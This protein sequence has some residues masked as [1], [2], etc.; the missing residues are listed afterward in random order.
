LIVKVKLEHLEHLVPLFEAYRSVFGVTDNRQR[1]LDYLTAQIKLG[2]VFYLRFEK[3]KAI[4]FCAIFRSFSTFALAPI[5]TINDLF[6]SSKYRNQGVASEL[7]RLVEENAKKEGV[8]SLKVS[9][10]VTNNQAK[11]L[12][13][14][15][16]FNKNSDFN[17]YSKT[18]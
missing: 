15:L 14:K 7:L 12:Y 2:A 10:Q 1:V 13:Q 17:L 3:S 11:C 8:F 4:G 9:T 6:V 5:D 18:I 16:G